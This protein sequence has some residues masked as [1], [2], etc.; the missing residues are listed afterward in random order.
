MAYL[1]KR[2]EPRHGERF[3]T[4]PKVRSLL[5]A[6]RKGRRAWQSG[7]HKR[8]YKYITVYIYIVFIYIYIEFYAAVY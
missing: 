2:V 3:A 5:A 8:I 1:S 6:A 4:S 7:Y